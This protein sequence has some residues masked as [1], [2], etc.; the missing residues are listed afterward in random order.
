M[1]LL[2][3]EHVRS[4]VCMCSKTQTEKQANDRT[5]EEAFFQYVQT[6]AYIDIPNLYREVN[7]Q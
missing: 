6:W 5:R 7:I 4:Y 3:Y 1:E 2:V